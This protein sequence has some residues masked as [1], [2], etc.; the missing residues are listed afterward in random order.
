MQNNFTKDELM[1]RVMPGGF[2][3]AII[4]YAFQGWLNLNTIDGI[5]FLYTFMFFCSSYIVGELLQTLAHEFEWLIDVFFRFRRPSEVFL[6]HK[7]PV[8]KN[9]YKRTEL[10]EKL[11]LTKELNVFNLEYS[12]LPLLGSEE[13]KE[14]DDLSQS[15]FWKIYSEVS[16][17]EEIKNA[18][19]TYLF[20]RVIMIEF[21]IVAAIFAIRNMTLTMISMAIFCFFLW[22]SRGV[23]RGL[24]LKTVL[25]YLKES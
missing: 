2:L 9:E 19:Q 18:N 16:D 22:R 3:L 5:D 13:Y 6:Y 8:L 12:N 1:L 24:V 4:L 21:L 23:A 15:I 10:I 25:I 7:N 20:T 11:R 17:N 14:R